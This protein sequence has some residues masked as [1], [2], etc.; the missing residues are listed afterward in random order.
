MKGFLKALPLSLQHLFAMFGAT[1]LVPALTGLDP[2]AALVASGVGT[3]I[4]H[5]ITRG[6]VPTY[7]GSSFAFIA[8]LALYVGDLK[9]PGQAVAGLISVSIVYAIV[10]III[11]YVGFEKVRKAIPPV[12]VRPVVSIIGL[13]LA[14]TA[15]SSMAAVNWDVAIVSLL[16]AFIALRRRKKVNMKRQEHQ[17]DDVL[18][19]HCLTIINQ[20]SSLSINQQRRY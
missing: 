6:K 11:T 17:S 12:V 4:F 2:G 1:I 10:S 7:L 14:T 5:L 3:L 18:A 8:P 16:A 13:A 20:T 15:V 19:F 9:S